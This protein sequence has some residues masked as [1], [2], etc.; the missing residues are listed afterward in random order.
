M[1]AYNAAAFIFDLLLTLGIVFLIYKSISPRLRDLLD[2]VIRLPEGTAFYMRALVLVLL[3]TVLSKVVTGI[4]LKP[5]AHFMEYVWAV[6][7]D[8][9][10]V[11]DN[12]FATLLVY[13]GV[14]TLLV[15]VLKP[16]NDK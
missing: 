4:H 3:C 2:K 9:S 16:K 13:V 10:G 6:A 11:F 8:L 15:V 1:P 12:I 7:A 14:V 5:D